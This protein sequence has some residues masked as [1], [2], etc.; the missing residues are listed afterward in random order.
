VC[1][2]HLPL[3][4]WISGLLA[5]VALPAFVKGAFVLGVMVCLTLWADDRFVRS[6]AVGALLTG[7]APRARPPAAGSEPGRASRARVDDRPGHV[8][9]RRRGCDRC[10]RL[11]RGQ[12]I[13]NDELRRRTP[14]ASWP[15]QSLPV[16]LSVAEDRADG[17][18]SRSRQR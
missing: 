17:R 13:R 5:P 11:V 7:G 3:T 8:G 10:D 4:I 12:F 18:R 9:G 14:G 16:G 15:G 1:L 6:T 2:V